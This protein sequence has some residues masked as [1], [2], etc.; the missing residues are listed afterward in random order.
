MRKVTIQLTPSMEVR[1]VYEPY[2]KYLK[3]ITTLNLLKVDF[4]K[5]L[6]LLIFEIVVK[7]EY[8][9]HN[10]KWPKSVVFYHILKEAGKTLTL[11]VKTNSEFFTGGLRGMHDLDVVLDSPSFIEKDKVIR[12]CIGDEINLKK[13]V[14]KMGKFG[15]ITKIAYKKSNYKETNLT[16]HLTDKQKEIL[17][18]AK[19][20]GYYKLPRK[21]NGDGLAKKIGCSKATVLEHLRKI[22]NKIMNNIDE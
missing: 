16:S 8:D 15:E 11:L 9:F 21:I 13:F 1:K 6:E 19:I 3:R 14:A 22:E 20:E 4:L 5:N 10:I 17:N 12:S 2:F 7:D 18:L